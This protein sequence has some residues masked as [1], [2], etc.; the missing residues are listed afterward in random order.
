MQD[1]PI[2]CPADLE[3]TEAE[4]AA[5]EAP[6]RGMRASGEGQVPPQPS[7]TPTPTPSPPKRPI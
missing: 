4:Q 1:A 6:A 2:H 5:C 3:A 7:P